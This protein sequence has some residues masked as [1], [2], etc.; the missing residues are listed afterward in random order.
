MLISCQA[1]DY[2]EI[3]CMRAS[4]VHLQLYSGEQV[5]GI[6]EDISRVGGIECLQLKTPAGVIS[7]DL[8]TIKTLEARD[9]LVNA[10]NFSVQL[11]TE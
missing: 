2:V 8:M 1:H 9:N 7:V 4:R 11:R 10:H 5:A 6:A 3:V